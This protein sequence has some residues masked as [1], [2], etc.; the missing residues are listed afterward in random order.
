MTNAVKALVLDFGGV[1]TRTMFETHTMTER[2][3]GLEPGTLTWR[4]PFAPDSDELWCAMERDEITE[5]EYWAQRTKEVGELVGRHWTAMS[6]FV[7]AARGAN[8]AEVIR[9]QAVHAI[10]TAR[11]NGCKLAIVSNE[12]DLFYGADFRD[13]LPFMKWFDVIVDATHTKILKPDPRA[14]Q[15]CIDGLTVDASQC[16]FVDD[17]HRNVVG[18]LAVGMQAVHFDVQRPQTSYE[19]ALELLSIE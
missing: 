14:Y 4:G 3:L 7:T 16:V 2:A 18:A 10:E 17:Q 9:P 11:N 1:V 15:A 19:Q 8:P 6:D 13:R 12:L 5:R